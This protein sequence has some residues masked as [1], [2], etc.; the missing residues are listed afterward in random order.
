M[1]RLITIAHQSLLREGT[2]GARPGRAGLPRGA[3]HPGHPPRA[4]RGAPAAAPRCRCSS[5]RTRAI[6]ESHE[7]LSWTDKHADIRAAAVPAEPGARAEVDCALPAPR[8]RPRATRGAG[9]ST[10][11][12]SASRKLVFAFNDRG[13]LAW[14]DGML[15]GRLAAD[16]AACRA[17]AWD[18]SRRRARQDEAAV[19]HE[20]DACRRAAVRRAPIPVRRAL[21]RRGP[22]LRGT[23]PPR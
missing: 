16:E 8:R 22:D 12:C 11:T 18:P 5:Q 2:L 19:F 20:L 1:L 23:R 3:S 17:G 4:Q 14:E 15:R 21:R 6:G 13:V 9:S 10:C 7:I